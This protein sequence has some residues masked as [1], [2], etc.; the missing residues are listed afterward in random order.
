M[1]KKDPSFLNYTFHVCLSGFFLFTDCSGGL[2][3]NVMRCQLYLVHLVVLLSVHQPLPAAAAGAPLSQKLTTRWC[4]DVSLADF[5]ET[6]E[7]CEMA[8]SLG[9]AADCW[10]SLDAVL[11]LCLEEPAGL[12]GVSGR[13]PSTVSGRTCRAVWR[14]RTPWFNCVWKSL[15]GCLASLDAVIQLCLEEPV[16]LFGV[17]ARRDSTV[18]GRACRA[19]RRLWTPWFNC[20]WKSLPGCLASPDAVLQLC[21]EEAAAAG[22]HLETYGSTDKLDLLKRNRNKFLGK[23]DGGARNNFLGKR[24]GVGRLRG[25]N[26]FFGKQLAAAESGEKRNRNKFLGKRTQNDGFELDSISTEKRSRNKFLGKRSHL[27][28]LPERS[29][30]VVF[31]NGDSDKRSRNDFLGKR[32]QTDIK[33]SRNKFLG[34]RVDLDEN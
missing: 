9:S 21:L 30:L 6:S 1:H 28:D 7:A 26:A 13:R 20:V 11:Q 4:S 10:A 32:D 5:L 19:V 15:P 33:R 25:I 29:A 23:R 16:G 18:S 2:A 24:D 12:F 27:E 31:G 14:P 3:A 22:H 8:E 17:P 34:K